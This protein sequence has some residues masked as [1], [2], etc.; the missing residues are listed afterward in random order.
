MFVAAK[1]HVTGGKVGVGGVG[2][3]KNCR[4]RKEN[5]NDLMI[6]FAETGNFGVNWA[7]LKAY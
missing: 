5:G 3:K 7:T 1:D 2:I 6:G 4:C